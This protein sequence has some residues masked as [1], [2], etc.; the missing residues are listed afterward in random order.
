MLPNRQS[1]SYRTP[2][3]DDG[4]VSDVETGV[5]GVEDKQISLTEELEIEDED[6]ELEDN[7][8]PSRDRSRPTRHRTFHIS[9]ETTSTTAPEVSD[10]AR[11]LRLCVERGKGS[12]GTGPIAVAATVAK[13][14]VVVSVVSVIL[15]TQQ[16]KCMY[17]PKLFVA[18]GKQSGL[19][20]AFGALR[21]I[22][23]RPDYSPRRD[24]YRDYRTSAFEEQ[25][26]EMIEA[27]ED[28]DDDDVDDMFAV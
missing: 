7:T 5:I 9:E 19:M 6:D 15:G 14:R 11:C 2:V 20:T 23:I 26:V 4:L 27:E 28:E 3:V 18:W 12:S 16:E 13:A 8:R 1:L 21:R 25:D 24:R 10:V 22:D 17:S